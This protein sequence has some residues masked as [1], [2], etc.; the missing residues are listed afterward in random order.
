MNKIISL[1]IVVFFNQIVFAQEKLDSVSFNN[2][3]LIGELYYNN[4][5]LMTPKGESNDFFELLNNYKTPELKNV[6][7]LLEA[8]RKSDNSVI[9]KKYL[10]RPNNIDLQYW[11]VIREI[12]YNLVDSLPKDNYKIARTILDS[13][14]DSRALLDNYYYRLSRGINFNSGNLS[15]LDFNIEEYGFRDDTEKAIFFFNINGQLIQ[16]FV[17]LQ[18]MKNSKKILEFAKKLPTFNGRNYY[19]YTDFNFSDFEWIGYEKIELYKESHLNSYYTGLMAHFGAVAE[20][21]GKK[22]SSEI[23]LNSILSKQEYFKYSQFED[24]L[25]KLY[26]QQ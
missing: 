17:V 13:T 6:V 7:E 9:D 8:S 21:K 11:Y 3:V 14:I 25:N 20:I 10:K 23:Y 1:I 2:L 24:L 18:M 5:K 19:F 26:E 4:G 15:K 12:H 16:R 22:K